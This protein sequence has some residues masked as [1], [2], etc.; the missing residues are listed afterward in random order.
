MSA[1]DVEL[2]RLRTA[3]NR[4][5]DSNTDDR[6]AVHCEWHASSGAYCSCV[7]LA[8]ITRLRAERDALKAVIER[9]RQLHVRNANTGDCEY[10]SKRDYPDYALPWPCGT[11]RA[12]AVPETPDGES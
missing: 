11:I 1:A 2:E 4:L 8:E 9:V 7:G 10:C 5:W 3:L 12:L 6:H